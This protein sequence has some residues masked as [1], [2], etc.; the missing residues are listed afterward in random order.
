MT[1]QQETGVRTPGQAG[2]QLAEYTE[3]SEHTQVKHIR[4]GQTIT[5][6]ENQT[7]TGRL[8]QTTKLYKWKQE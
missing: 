5:G 1:K 4:A 2:G 3:E 7:K 8:R 6:A